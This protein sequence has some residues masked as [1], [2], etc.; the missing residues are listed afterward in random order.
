MTR[1]TRLERLDALIDAIWGPGGSAAERRL[2]AAVRARFAGDRRRFSD[3]LEWSLAESPG[4]V[5]LARFS[6]GFPSWRGERADVQRVVRAWAE[7]LG[8]GVAAAAGAFLRAAASP[9][10]AQVLVGYA[11]GAGEPPRAKLYL[12]FADDAGPAALRLAR[13]VTGAAVPTSSDGL[14]LHLLG[15][16]V[17][18]GGLAGSKLYFLQ[19]RADEAAV[20]RW[21]GWRRALDGVLLIH[22]A[23]APDDEAVA[24]PAAV[25]FAVDG[26]WDAVRTSPAARRCGRGLDAFAALADGFRLRPR[27]VSFSLGAPAMNLYYVLDEAEGA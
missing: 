6:Y 15:L 14:P 17:G 19:A 23:R 20:E 11:R 2:L 10:V 3:V 13:A 12:Q 7:A 27:R 21:L 26:A 5:D 9:A 1:N 18:E 16:D 8:P 22:R 4:G 24:Q 25:D